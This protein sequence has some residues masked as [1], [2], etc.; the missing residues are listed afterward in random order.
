MRIVLSTGLLL[1]GLLSA[2][3]H[4]FGHFSLIPTAFWRLS[5]RNLF[6]ACKIEGLRPREKVDT[7]PSHRGHRPCSPTGSPG[8]VVPPGAPLARP[9]AAWDAAN[10]SSTAA[11][12][13]WLTGGSPGWRSPTQNTAPAAAAASISG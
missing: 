10:A 12:A 13:P 5:D 2:N 1:N 9:V 7:S 11:S 6:W 4:L 8:F 3:V